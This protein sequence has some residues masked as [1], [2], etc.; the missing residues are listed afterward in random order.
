MKSTRVSIAAI[1][2]PNKVSS[3]TW[4]QS[5][6]EWE[7]VVQGQIGWQT[8]TISQLGGTLGWLLDC[9]WV[10]SLDFNFSGKQ[11]FF[12]KPPNVTLLADRSTATKAGGCCFSQMS[13]GSRSNEFIDA[14][15]GFAKRLR[16]SPMRGL[17]SL[18]GYRKKKKT[19]SVTKGSE[20][21]VNYL[22]SQVAFF[23]HC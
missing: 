4:D 6:V 9:S 19:K 13:Q 3:L 12:T 21:V 5:F 1:G 16:G 22:D 15:I 11:G 20:F 10:G 14:G 7:E 23:S 8:H 17:L 2:F 18:F